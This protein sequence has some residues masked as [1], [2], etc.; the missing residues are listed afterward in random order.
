MYEEIIQ[1]LNEHRCAT[2]AAKQAAYLKN[3]FVFFGIA[4]PERRQLMG[5]Y[6]KSWRQSSKID[7]QLL[8]NLW[9]TDYRECQYVALDFLKSSQKQLIFEDVER[10]LPMIQTK[11]WW[12][13]IDCFDQLLGTIG[14]S[15][16][17]VGSLMLQWA[18]ADDFW[19]RRIAIDHQ[20]GRREQT[21]EQLL[22]AIILKN[23]RETNFFIKKA[24]GW[25]LRDYSK[26]NP[27][28]VK[29]FIE[30]NKD[31]LQSLSIREA[32]KHVLS[33]KE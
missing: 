23:K 32:M 4:T 21:N 6:L 12:D 25:A 1:I 11:Q 13:S 27:E 16:A 33:K 18:E 5:P 22:A 17:R 29:K 31:Q 7:W 8:T 3:H 30:Q 2:N 26:T 24:I 19:L 15:D 20:L 14:L 28:W 10:M 9:Q